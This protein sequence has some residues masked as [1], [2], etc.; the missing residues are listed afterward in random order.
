MSPQD[1]PNPA[2]VQTRS[3]ENR[4]GRRC[5]ARRVAREARERGAIPPPGSLEIPIYRPFALLALTVTLGITETL[6]FA[7][8]AAWVTAGLRATE[9]RFPSDWLMATGAWWFAVALASQTAVTGRRVGRLG[10]P[11]LVGLNAGVLLAVLAGHLPPTS[12]A[13]QTLLALAGLG[14][15]TSL[16]AG[17]VAV[18]A[19]RPEPRQ[20][21][22][23]HLDRIESRFFRFAFACAALR[24]R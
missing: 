16:L 17:G 5:V 8:F 3:P 9:P 12:P 19:W 7:I 1:N 14:M 4:P 2:R 24:R 22:P 11:A 23:L 10:I 13:T 20:A 18:G 6:A 21:V 15:V